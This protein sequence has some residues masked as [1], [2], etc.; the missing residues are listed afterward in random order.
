MID[1]DFSDHLRKLQKSLRA[2]GVAKIDEP[3]K[4]AHCVSCD[5]Q[6]TDLTDFYE[7]YWEP[8]VRGLLKVIG[9][10]YYMV[11]IQLRDDVFTI[12]VSNGEIE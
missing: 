5:F 10:E 9:P 7:K 1:F 8:A 11:S 4:N 6:T 3:K 12:K 2:G